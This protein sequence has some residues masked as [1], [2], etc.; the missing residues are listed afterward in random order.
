LAILKKIL[1]QANI[2]FCCKL[3]H[4]EKRKRYISNRRSHNEWTEDFRYL[5]C[6]HETIGQ[7]ASEEDMTKFQKFEKTTAFTKMELIIVFLCCSLEGKSISKY[8]LYFIG[9]E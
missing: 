9:F 3:L 7:V 5:K 4:E 6:S 8:P 1:P 2:G